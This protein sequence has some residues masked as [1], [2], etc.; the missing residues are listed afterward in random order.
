MR[1]V[2]IT[3]N[4]IYSAVLCVFYAF[5][6]E[7]RVE[8]SPRVYVWEV[9]VSKHSRNTGHP[10]RPL[11]FFFYFLQTDVQLVS[12]DTFRHILSSSSIRVHCPDADSVVKHLI[13]ETAGQ[14][15]KKILSGMVESS[16]LLIAPRMKF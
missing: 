11:I 1:P 5:R 7:V 10:N 15:A 6:Q 14:K 4:N 12:H 9:P 13:K 16:F 2:Y 8:I 3:Q